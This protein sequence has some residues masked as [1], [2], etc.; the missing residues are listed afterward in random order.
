MTV[1]FRSMREERHGSPQVGPSGR[2]LGVRP[3]HDTLAIRDDELVV[4]GTGGM[5]V[6][7]RDPRNLPEH[8]RPPSFQGTSRD[9]VWRIDE[10]QLPSSLTYRPDPRNVRHGFIEPAAAMTLQEYQHALASTQTCWVVVDSWPEQEAHSY[11]S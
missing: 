10:E 9:P 11:D 1:L 4:P 7:P 5:S 2:T 6:S 3:G 8:R